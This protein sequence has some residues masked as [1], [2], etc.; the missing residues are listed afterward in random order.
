MI[1]TEKCP[2]PELIFGTSGLGNLYEA[3][4]S[5]T[6]WQIVEECVRVA[7]GPLVFDTA[8]KYGAGLALE[9]LGEGLRKQ[10]TH[11][12]EVVISNKLGWYRTALKGEEPSFEPGVWKN[13]EH[14]AV[15]RIDYDGI[16]ACYEQGNTLL[17]GYRAGWVSVHDPDEYLAAA[18][19]PADRARRFGD[20]LSAYEALKD[21]KREGSVTGVGIGSKDWTVVRE[22]C[23]MVEMD[24]VMIANSFTMHHHPAELVAFMRQL[25]ARG[26]PVINAAVFN[27][28]FLTG[29][30]FYNYRRVSPQTH[31]ELYRWREKMHA[32]CR[33]F[34]ILPAA[35]CVAFAKSAPGV[36]S[37]AL[38]MTRDYRAGS[39]VDI[40]K[41]SIPP[42]CW[43]RMAAENL[44]D[45]HFAETHLYEPDI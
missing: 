24:W 35:A 41:S 29:Q 27:G 19:S 36:R 45:K 40:L 8:G 16:V 5:E 12:G 10:G 38:N 31:S 26:I 43:E 30:D 21:L 11:P 17:N 15:Q 20:V 39:Q 23:E 42:A 1:S 3:W 32:V 4:S 7:P 22:I 2:M 13:L 34:G 25:D 37:I 33:E 14:D 9:M 6:K 44:I 18:V 28:G